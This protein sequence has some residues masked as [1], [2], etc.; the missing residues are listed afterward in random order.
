MKSFLATLLI[1]TYA[2]IAVYACDDIP[3]SP[4]KTIKVGFFSYQLIQAKTNPFDCAGSKTAIGCFDPDTETI[5]Y[6]PNMT[7][8]QT[9]LSIWHEV[10]HA[11]AGYVLHD[12]ELGNEAWVES[13]SAVTVQVIKD[14]PALI[15]YLELK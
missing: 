6:A 7:L 5:T 9:Q 8:H 3:S 2:L 13:V 1:C 15:H 12:A 14:N 10:E 11:I 4:P